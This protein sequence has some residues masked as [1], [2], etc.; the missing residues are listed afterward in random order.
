VIRFGILTISDRSASGER[1]DASGPV[2]EQVVA[3]RGWTVTRRQILPDDVD[4]VSDLLAD[5]SDSGEVDVI[6]TTGGT[7]FSPRDITPEATLLVIDKLAPGMAEAMRA[8]S[9]QVTAH[10]MLSRAVV[11]IRGQ[12][13]IANLPGSPK[14][15]REN[16]QVI[17]PAI[18]H[19]VQVLRG[20]PGVETGHLQA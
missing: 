13:L 2:L 4:Q 3:G 5:W 18:P 1:P 10:A 16:L 8:A 17:L 11:G 15:A 20:D 14:G 19:A 7:G 6:L 9:L 12:T